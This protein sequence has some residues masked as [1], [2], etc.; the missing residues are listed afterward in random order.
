M[1]FAFDPLDRRPASQAAPAAPAR[2]RPHPVEA[3]ADAI[4]RSDEVRWALVPPVPPLEALAAVDAAFGHAAELAAR[5]REL[6]FAVDEETGRMIIEVR[7]L[8]GEALRTIA[9]SEVLDVMSGGT[10]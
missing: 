9:P 3:L 2:Q 1:D 4:R 8:D 5:N 10:F 6:H 7:T